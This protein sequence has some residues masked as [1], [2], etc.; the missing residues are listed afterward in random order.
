MTTLAYHPFTA[1]RSLALGLAGVLLLSVSQAAVVNLTDNGSV[2]TVNLDSSAGMSQWTVTGLPAGMENQ[3]NQQWFWYRIDGQNGGLA[4]PINNIGAAS[5]DINHPAN[6]VSATYANSDV[7]VTIKYTLTGG[8]FGQADIQEGITLQN[9]HPE[10]PFNFHFYQYSD[11]NLLNSAAGDS[12]SLNNSTVVQWKGDTQI[13]ESI[14]APDA[15]FF[16][17]N[18]TGGPTSTLAKLGSIANLNLNNQTDSGPGD[19][20]WSYQWDF[21]NLTTQTIQKDKLLDVTFVPEP[22]ALALGALG[23]AGFA[24][25]RR[26]RA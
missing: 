26:A 16:E 11:F 21:M 15:N 14:V 24:L 2:A 12:V 13:Q 19:A 22:S 1:F 17:A 20:T 7:S 5:F 3:L 23:L 18:L 6:Q 25:R 8:G 10:T 4:Q 9:L